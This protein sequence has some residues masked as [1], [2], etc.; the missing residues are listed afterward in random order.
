MMK[1]KIIFWVVV[2]F[3]THSLVF[4]GGAMRGKNITQASFEQ[5]FEKADAHVILGHYSAYRDIAL[6]IQSAGN[7]RAK[8][9]AELMATTMFESLS[10]CLADREC[11]NEIESKAKQVAPEVLGD[12]PFPIEKRTS[13]N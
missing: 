3:I 1:K 2:L 5:A 9:E 6:G 4:V 8:C 10:R 11:K 7:G 13:C 12:R